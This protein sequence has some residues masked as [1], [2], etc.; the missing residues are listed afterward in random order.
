[1]ILKPVNAENA[2]SILQ[3]L[4]TLNLHL[5]ALNAVNDCE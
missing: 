4:K 2:A 5:I 1:M 3:M